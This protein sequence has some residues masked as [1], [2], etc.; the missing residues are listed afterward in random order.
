M[1]HGD[2]DVVKP[3]GEQGRITGRRGDDP[4]ARL[5]QHVDHRGVSHHDQRHIC[6]NRTIS[7][8]T[9]LLQIPPALL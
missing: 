9:Y 7:E 6:T 5:G 1:K 2:A 3:V 4:D 8:L